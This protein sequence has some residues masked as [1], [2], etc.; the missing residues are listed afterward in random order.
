VLLEDSRLREYGGNIVNFLTYN[1]RTLDRQDIP[2]L[3]LSDE[4]KSMFRHLAKALDDQQKDMDLLHDLFYS[5][6]APPTDTT[7]I[8]K[9]KSNPL[10]CFIAISHMDSSGTFKSV[11]DV[12]P[13]F[14][15]WEYNIR[16]SAIVEIAKHDG[17]IR[18]MER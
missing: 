8:G 11:L 7:P 6:S 5:F 2:Q 10:L 13:D 15:R 9:W 12:T 14:A 16:S 4:Q 1:L 3:P 17:S 18:D